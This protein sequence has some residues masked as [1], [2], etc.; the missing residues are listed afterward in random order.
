[1]IRRACRKATT[2][3]AAGILSVLTMCGPGGA[4]CCIISHLGTTCTPGFGTTLTVDADSRTGV[5]NAAHSV[6]NTELWIDNNLE[7]AEGLFDFVE[8]G[9][10]WDCPDGGSVETFAKFYNWS[11]TRILYPSGIHDVFVVA[12]ISNGTSCTTPTDTFAR[13]CP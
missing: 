10:Q 12:E 3:G 5:T 7:D 6:T 13:Q 4:A 8:N 9:G 11:N 2:I 1:M